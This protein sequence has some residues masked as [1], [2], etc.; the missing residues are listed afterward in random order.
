MSCKRHLRPLDSEVAPGRRFL[1]RFSLHSGPAAGRL[2]G[3]GAFGAGEC[4]GIDVSAQIGGG[5]FVLALPAS[6]QVGSQFVSGKGRTF[7]NADAMVAEDC[8]VRG[9]RNLLR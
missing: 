4:F 7:L 9:D 6:F 5:E 3:T 8:D 1:L 2:S